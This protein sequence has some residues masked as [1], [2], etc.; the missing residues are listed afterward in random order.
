MIVPH[1]PVGNRCRFWPRSILLLF[2]VAVGLRIGFVLFYP[3]YPF[4][5]GDDRGYDEVGWNLATGRGFSAEF[6]GETPRVP[7]R[8]PMDVPGS[9]EVRRGPVYPAFLALIYLTFGHDLAAVRVI[10]ALMS[11]AI[12]LILYPRVQ[13]AFGNEVAKLS[14]V[15]LAF[16]PAFI[17]YSG[18]VLTETLFLFLLALLVSALIRAVQS[19][20]P[21][22]WVLAGSLMGITILLRQEALAMVPVFV[23]L[24]LWQF[25]QRGLIRKV[26]L[27]LLVTVLT[28][29]VWTARNYLVFQEF[30]LVT[31]LGGDDLWLS[32]TAWTEYP[33]DD[34]E[35][36]SLVQG[37]NYIDR[38]TILRREGIRNILNDP[39]Y[40]LILCIKRL[41]RFWI[42]SHTEQLVGLSDTYKQYYMHG[43][44]GKL[45]VKI[46]LLGANISLILIGVL[47]AFITLKGGKER[48]GL[49]LFFL[50]PIVVIAIVHF[51]LPATP[52]Y[53]VPIMPFILTFTAAALD[54]FDFMK[55][56]PLLIR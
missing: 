44:F 37:L 45:F 50:V 13:E 32:T 14:G 2:V 3:Q 31:A 8:S 36:Q 52:R 26:S 41:P 6:T 49:T 18:V 23:A 38:N 40:Y 22:R 1:L 33:H 27:F 51:F 20:S 11:A 28:V 17:S 12:L 19:D 29:G 9:P 24:I 25:P 35:F 55:R 54:R 48:L 15:L 53:N 34:E 16:Y 7:S 10:Q 39:F 46:M 4:G 43:A 56:L 5:R 47:G 21:W 42:G 30:I